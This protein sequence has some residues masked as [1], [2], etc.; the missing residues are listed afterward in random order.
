M[1]NIP[2]VGLILDFQNVFEQT[3]PADRL[4]FLKRNGITKN[5]VLSRLSLI[6]FMLSPTISTRFDYSQ[7]MQHSILDKMLS[8]DNSHA[9]IGVLKKKISENAIIFNRPTNLFAMMEII[10]SDLPEG[11]KDTKVSN[12]Q[13]IDFFG[14]YL[15]VNHETNT[16]GSDYD[17]KKPDLEHLNISFIAHNE[18][19]ED[20]DP[21]QTV[22]RGKKLFEW[23][24]SNTDYKDLFNEY[25]FEISGKNATE[26]LIEIVSIFFASESAKE[27]FNFYF[28]LD[29]EVPIFKSF[30][31]RTI[32]IN[33]GNQLEALDIRKSPI[34]QLD[35]ESYILLDNKFLLEKCYNLIIWDFLFE[36]LVKEKTD[37]ERKR[38]IIEYRSSIGYFFEEY[39][40]EKIDKSLPHMKHPKPKL[41]D[42]L[43]I[44]GKEVGDIYIRENKK[45]ILGEVK[46][47]GIPSKS[48]YGET[49]SDLYA[50]DR[51]KF[52]KIH[53]LDQLITNLNNLL[54]NP[55]EYDT[56]LDLS[57]KN[58]IFPI[59]VTNEVA[60]TLGFTIHV[61]NQ[62]FNS[63]FDRSKHDNQLIKPVMIL[64]ISDL[65]FLEQYLKDKSINIFDF[66]CQHYRKFDIIPKLSMSY[67]HLAPLHDKNVGALIFGDVNNQ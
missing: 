46:S 60:L 16:I 38:I 55:N 8:I 14:Y 36:K 33:I 28:K 40:R 25:I 62:E 30:S 37:R 22:Y 13:E 32:P 9:A 66:L 20:V 47:S 27:E 53:G 64:H 65:E 58:T 5:E 45:V 39:V 1:K 61:F 15:S 63:R 42:D 35:N 50:N 49:L 12:I 26:Y 29:S 21:I 34:Y 19:F 10:N 56:K 31:D 11:T 18:Y 67:N 54:T 48:K 24:E 7:E 57:K 52:F 44:G 6:N 4:A 43:K 41:F 23:I 2:K 59:I 17:P 51:P 3:A